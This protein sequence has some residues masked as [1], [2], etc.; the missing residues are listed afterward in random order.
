VDSPGQAPP[1]YPSKGSRHRCA[2]G[3]LICQYLGIAARSV[4]MVLL[5]AWQLPSVCDG[6]VLTAFVASLGQHHAHVID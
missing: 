4:Y 2:V 6:G 3:P 5:F 1:M